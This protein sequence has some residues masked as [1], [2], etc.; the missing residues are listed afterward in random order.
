MP[1]GR[2]PGGVLIDVDGTL[3]DS[4]FAHARAF[5]DV[6]AE[7]GFH[8]PAEQIFPLIG[9]GGSKLV[10]SL[11]EYDEDD[12]RVEEIAS[13]HGD[14]FLEAYLPTLQPTPGARALLERLR[15]LGFRLVVATSSREEQLRAL[16]ERA[17]VA[18]LLPRRTSASDVEEAKP[19]PDVIQEAL[20]EGGLE[21]ADAV[22][23]G[24]TPYDVE[25]A[26]RAGVRTIAVRCGGW[27][28]EKLEGSVAIY[29]DPAHL[30]RELDQSLLAHPP[31]ARSER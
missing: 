31:R 7:R 27:D 11:T 24:D 5:A 9:M 15:E 2:T 23:L 16:L 8:V 20:R 22:L 21:A 13:A 17:G 19:E 4:N 3:I 14:R 10:A 6:L 30:L 25:A 1:D 12:E 18:D 26:S 28:D 29:D